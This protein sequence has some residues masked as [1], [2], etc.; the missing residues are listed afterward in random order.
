LTAEEVASRKAAGYRPADIYQSDRALHEVIDGIS[1][2]AFS[3]GDREL[4]KP[5]VDSLLSRDEYM[6]FADY[7]SYITCQ[8][9]VAE[10]YRDQEEWSRMSILNAARMGKFS[11]DRSIREYCEKIWRVDGVKVDD[12]SDL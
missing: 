2:G 4:F 6:L 12:R 1:S 5:L 9:R 7:D 8:D 10:A 3:R 11:S